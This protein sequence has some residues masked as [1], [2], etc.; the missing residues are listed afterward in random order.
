[1]RAV[2]IFEPDFYIAINDEVTIKK[3]FKEVCSSFNIPPHLDVDTN[4]SFNLNAFKCE[5]IAARIE[6][7]KTMI[8]DRVALNGFPLSI[9]IDAAFSDQTSV[10]SIYQ[11]T[12][13]DIVSAAAVV[14]F[15][16]SKSTQEPKASPTKKEKSISESHPVDHEV[17]YHIN[18]NQYNQPMTFNHLANSNLER[19]F[20]ALKSLN[21]DLIKSVTE[22]KSDQMKLFEMIEKKS[23]Q[24]SKI[25]ENLTSEVEGLQNENKDLRKI[26]EEMSNTL[27]EKVLPIE[28]FDKEMK[29][30]RCKIDDYH[31]SIS[32]TL[33]ENEKLKLM[34]SSKP[35]PVTINTETV[36]DLELHSTPKEAW[37]SSN[38]EKRVLQKTTYG[39][40]HTSM[41][42]EIDDLSD[43]NSDINLLSDPTEPDISTDSAYTEKTKKLTGDDEFVNRHYVKPSLQCTHL[44]LGDSNLKNVNRRRLDK[45][46]RTDIRTFRGATIK[47]MTA[48]LNKSK[49]QYPQVKKITVCVGTN[50]CSKPVIDCEN[51]IHDMTQLTTSI[52]SVFPS[53]II[54][55]L[56]IPP[57][58]VPRLNK[59]IQKVNRALKKH[60]PTENVIFKPCDALWS[61]VENGNIDNGILVSDG[62]HLSQRGLGLLLKS[63][64]SFFYLDLRKIPLTDDSNGVTP[65]HI[66]DMRSFSN[67]DMKGNT[68][69]FKPEIKIQSSCEKKSSTALPKFFS[70]FKTKCAALLKYYNNA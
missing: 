35:T 8:I 25:V 61:H 23:A 42:T 24:H 37:K 40:S 3:S 1:M 48:I 11:E 70:K 15:T 18:T 27:I 13:E 49:H 43:S 59:F 30:L 60:I 32:C 20:Q 69:K 17:F 66:H 63:V 19:E 12:E 36:S 52:K 28:D 21:K 31:K 4:I 39:M 46:G 5:E 26:V 38:N 7:K 54:C 6:P 50:D 44:F 53:A 9:D 68:A 55:I 65:S 2:G 29:S 41:T 56:A 51:I 33:E 57:R 47:T 16:S 67:V 34:A 58:N 14:P 10:K 64:I 45:S 22:M 62:I